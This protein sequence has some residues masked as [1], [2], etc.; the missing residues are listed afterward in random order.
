MGPDAY[1]LRL[2]DFGYLT[3]VVDH[4]GAELDD[5][6]EG[7]AELVSH[8]R[9]ELILRRGEYGGSTWMRAERGTWIKA[10]GRH[11]NG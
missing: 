3:K 1:F 5:G 7:G 9:D 2:A 6:V 4:C 10:E 11:A 8:D